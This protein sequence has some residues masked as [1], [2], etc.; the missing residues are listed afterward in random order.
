MLMEN[1]LLKLHDAINKHDLEAFVN[2]FSEN[3][4]SE[5]PVHPDRIFKGRE[6]VRKNWSA[7]FNEMRD[8]RSDLLRYRID[9]DLIWSEWEWQGTRQ[10]KTTLQMRG[11]IL[12]GINGNEIIW[13]RLYMEP[14]QTQGE[15][16]DASVS[17]VM[18]GKK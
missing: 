4:K 12:F 7:N 17:K 11:V 15:G 6:Q 8:F 9:P 2:C 14:V 16:I 10:N 3:Y 18:I 13:G 5:Q 1:L